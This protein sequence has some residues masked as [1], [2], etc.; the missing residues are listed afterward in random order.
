M[1]GGGK[2]KEESQS[3]LDQNSGQA[4]HFRSSTFDCDD[5]DENNIFTVHKK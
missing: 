3:D 1:S 5:E 4:N 2:R